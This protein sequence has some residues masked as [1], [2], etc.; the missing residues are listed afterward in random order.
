MTQT[1]VPKHATVTEI[2]TRL[3]DARRDLTPELSKLVTYL[4]DNPNEIGVSSI[5][6]LAA[7]AD[8]KPNT[9]VRLSHAIGMESYEAFREVFRDSIRLGRDTY[10][11]RARWL[12]AV[13][14]RG[15]MGGLFAASA[16][17][18]IDNIEGVF[19]SI[20]H[21]AID[22][23]AKKIVD[24]HRCY[25]LGVG[26]NHGVV[27]NFAYLAAM[28]IDGVRALPQGGTLPIDGLVRADERDIL[29]AITF[30][31]YRREVVEAVEVA[32]SLNIPVIAISDSLASPIMADAQ[33]RFVIPV[34]TPQF[35]ISMVALTAFLEVLIAFIIAR[36]GGDVIKS[37]DA[38]H[39]QR[40][41]LG[42]YVEEKPPR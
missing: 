4:L 6:Q 41:D 36:A 30:R 7:K 12:Q 24:A 25:V 22:D 28:A 23:A 29:I 34:E 31:P 1:N 15:E 2:L 11:D 32:R 10:P 37:I 16:E 40:H 5:R 13:S 27:Q 38:Y 33:H 3:Q 39:R 9:L 26:V 42:I 35:F 19:A 8:V 17:S 21:Q 18:A 20:D 14:E